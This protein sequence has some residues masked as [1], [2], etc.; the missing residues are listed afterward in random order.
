MC[1]SCWRG[2]KFWLYFSWCADVNSPYKRKCWTNSEGLLYQSLLWG[3]VFY[4]QVGVWVPFSEMYPYFY[5]AAQ[6]RGNDDMSVPLLLGYFLHGFSHLDPSARARS[7]PT[8]PT[9]VKMTNSSIFLWNI[10]IK[11]IKTY[12]YIMYVKNTLIFFN[13]LTLL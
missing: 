10:Y 3:S 6:A 9:I 2:F 4:G 11:Y 7:R 13:S 8:D 12:V 1:C 5:P